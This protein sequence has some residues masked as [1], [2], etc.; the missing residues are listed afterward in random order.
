M[1]EREPDPGTER[2]AGN[3]R[4]DRVLAADYLG[5]LSARPLPEIRALR[6]EVEQE[7]ADVSYLRR[8]LQGRMDIVRA[9]LARRSAAGSGT[10]LDELPRILSEHSAGPRRGPSRQ[11][12]VEPSQPDAQRRS[13]EALVSDVTMDDVGARSEEELQA[14]LARYVDEEQRLSANR[15]ALHHVLDR[16]SAEITRRY[17]DGEADVGDLLEHEERPR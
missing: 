1:T 16:C 12:G 14:A 9:E 15:R 7:E 2:L 4:G 3:R 8:L 10:L 6:Q 13:V 11:A 17:R 5:N